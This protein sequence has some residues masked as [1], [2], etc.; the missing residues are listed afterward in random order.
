MR[1]P[2]QT[3]PI[4]RDRRYYPLRGVEPD[5]FGV[6]PAQELDYEED[7]EDELAEAGLGD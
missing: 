5:E 7:D 2:T 1:L 4:R 6:F 3:E